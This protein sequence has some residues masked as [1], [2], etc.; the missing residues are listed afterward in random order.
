MSKS[1]KNIAL[2]DVSALLNKH[3][4]K[5]VKNEKS[6]RALNNVKDGDILILNN[7]ST[8]RVY[9]ISSSQSE[10]SIITKNGL[11]ATPIVI[12]GNSDLI[13]AIDNR[14]KYSDISQTM[15]D[16]SDKVPSMA[17]VTH[18]DSLY[19]RKA[20][21]VNDFTTGGTDTVS[22]GGLS[23]LLY[24]MIQN[25][26]EGGVERLEYYLQRAE[27]SRFISKG[28]LA[29]GQTSIVPDN[30]MI[31]NPLIFIDGEILE[32]TQYTIDLTTATI[33]LK[34]AKEVAGSY[35]IVDE[36]T[37]KYKFSVESVPFLLSN[38][39]LSNQ[40]MI[41]DVIDVQGE[42][43]AYDGGAHMRRVEAIAG[44]NSVKVKDGMYLNEI[45]NSRVGSV[46][47]GVPSVSTAEDTDLYITRD[48]DNTIK[49]VCDVFVLNNNKAITIPKN[50]IINST[51]LDTGV[52]TIGVDYYIYA[53][54]NSVG[55]LKITIT[56]TKKDETYTFIGG[57]HYGVCRRHVNKQPINSSG[58]AWGSGWEDNVYGGILEFSLYTPKFR[59][60]CEPEGMVYIAG[61]VWVD[62]YISSHDG[63]NGFVSKHGVLPAVSI[64]GTETIFRMGIN[65]KTLLSVADF[66]MAAVGSPNGRDDSNEY[67]WSMTSNTSRCNT[68]H[69]RKAVSVYG[70]VD[71]SGNVWEWLS[72][73]V[74]R[75]NYAS[76]SWG[77]K[78]ET[79]NK[80]GSIHTYHTDGISQLRGGGG[81]GNGRHCGPGAL[82]LG[83]MP[84]D[85]G[86]SIGSRGRA[87][88]K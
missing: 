43:L 39:H 10:E 18:N 23:T 45:P 24:Q 70:C 7:R 67:A 68:G 8:F 22:S 65:N 82:T 55:N 71:F 11:Y 50:T 16:A 44:Y 28:D 74:V 60:I 57:F 62:I 69:V 83:A 15:N 1:R 48:T 51:H 6:I 73:V 2:K 81:Y 49:F 4:I 27:K 53:V 36:Y 14:V 79:E 61:G 54:I 84:W 46:T 34:K 37:A 5:Y 19:I 58:V 17:L 26:G 64:S 32:N 9:N 35:Y 33:T 77:W 40:L 42:V 75:Q 88:T 66:K 13:T 72:D 47:S 59:P 85:V 63:K 3:F 76:G 30:G 52:F 20:K 41:D 38:S 86:S 25:L 31:I 78:N 80:Y 87:Q 56:R 29:V 12:H 21:I